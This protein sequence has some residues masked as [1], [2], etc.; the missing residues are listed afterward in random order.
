MIEAI[1]ED[2][3]KGLIPFC[4]IATLGTTA[5]LAFDNILELGPIC[6]REKVY[7]SWAQSYSSNYQHIFTKSSFAYTTWIGCEFQIW[8]H[9]DAAYAGSAFIC[10]EYRPILNG[11]EFADS[12]NFNPH[13]VGLW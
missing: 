8:M 3:A 5:C 10:P 1:A 11:I 4:V 13:K 2:K 6:Q 9:I 7:L 12:F